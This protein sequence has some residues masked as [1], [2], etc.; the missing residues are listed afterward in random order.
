ME[1][2]LPVNDKFKGCELIFPDTVFFSKGKPSILIRSD[3]D[4]CLTAVKGSS[5]KGIEQRNN[6]LS[7]ANL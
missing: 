2:L 6:R 1:N 4:F 5:K 7:I 3:K